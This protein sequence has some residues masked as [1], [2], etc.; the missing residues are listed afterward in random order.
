MHVDW[1]RQNSEVSGSAA[2][3]VCSRITFVVEVWLTTTTT[4]EVGSS[5]QDNAV[6]S[7][8]TCNLNRGFC[9]C[10]LSGLLEITLKI[11]CTDSSSGKDQDIVSLLTFIG[12]PAL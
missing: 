11:L 4:Q 1:A 6:F 8:G 7:C 2:C 3:N 5:M 12:E 9:I 10:L